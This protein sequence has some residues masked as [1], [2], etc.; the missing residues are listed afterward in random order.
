MRRKVQLQ[1]ELVQGPAAW[2]GLRAEGQGPAGT[3]WLGLSLWRNCLRTLRNEMDRGDGAC[4][5][6]AGRYLP[7]LP[8]TGQG[9]VLASP[10]SPACIATSTR[11]H[12]PPPAQSQ[13]PGG[14]SAFSQMSLPLKTSPGLVNQPPDSPET[15]I[16]SHPRA[17]VRPRTWEPRKGQGRSSAQDTLVPCFLHWPTHCPLHK[18]PARVTC[19]G[20]SSSPNPQ[21]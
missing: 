4:R 20:C 19:K 10:L 1:G 15:D 17:V 5:W 21:P 7:D 18:V 11:G 2:E 6:Q 13:L 16:G 14:R 12:T 9:S 8:C 3:R